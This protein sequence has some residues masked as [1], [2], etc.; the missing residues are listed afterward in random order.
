MIDS[1]GLGGFLA[2]T[3]ISISLLLSLV[4]F[5]SL[6]R[7]KRELA[8]IWLSCSFNAV[9]FLYFMGSVSRLVSLFVVVV[10]PILNI[11]FIILYVR[12]KKQ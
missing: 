11:T 9:A 7:K 8:W 10:W 12:K 3:V 5:L 6:V 2:N 1:I 4:F